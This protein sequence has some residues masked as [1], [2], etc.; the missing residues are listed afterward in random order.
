MLSSLILDPSFRDLIL[1]SLLDGIRASGNNEVF[2]CGHRFERHL[3]IIPFSTNL[4]ED[5]ESQ[6]MKHMIA[7]PPGLRRCDL[8]RRFNA[9]V[10]YSGLKFS[11]SHEGFFVEN[12][13]KVIVNAIENVLNEN[14]TKDDKEHKH[15][16]EAQLQCLRRLF[17]SKSGFEAF[18]EVHGVREKLGSLVVRVLSWKSE[19]I[20]HATVEALCALMYPMHDQYELRIEQLNKQSL[21]SSPKFVENLLD[22]I[23]TH[24]VST[25]DSAKLLDQFVIQDRSTGWL[26]IASMLN[27]LTFSV[28]SPYSETTSGDTFDNI[29][30]M[31][32]VRG[33]SFFRLFQCPSMTIVKGAGMVM[34]AII[35]EADVETSK[36]MQ[37]LALSEGA[38]LTH[39]FMSLLSSGKDL[40]VLTNKQ[41]SGH[42]I[43]LW[44]ADNQP[45]NDLLI[46]TLVRIHSDDTCEIKFSAPRI[47]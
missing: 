28:C 44:I 22:L 31:V 37:M 33:R 42:L 1:A 16:T 46:R 10:P 27:F 3:R 4:D 35:E 38:F 20:D 25:L 15:K 13:G 5:S 6:C 26:V 36:S 2:V 29:L 17:A 43:S 11:K 19:S 18:T 40:R 21:M 39:L 32:S 30:K 45:A 8:I 9:N 34:R 41:L 14:Y 47:A 12:K 7:P 23:V 24:V